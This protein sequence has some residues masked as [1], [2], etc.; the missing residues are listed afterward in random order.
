VTPEVTG[1]LHVLALIPGIDEITT[2]NYHGVHERVGVKVL[3]AKVSAS[4]R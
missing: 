1:E 2:R 3:R 4:L